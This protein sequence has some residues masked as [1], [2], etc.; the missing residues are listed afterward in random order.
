MVIG[1]G[2]QGAAGRDRRR[3]QPP[4]Q[5]AHPERELLGRERLGEVVVGAEREAADPV[6]LLPPRGQQD[7]ADVLGLVPLA[8]LGQHVVA[9]HAGQHEVEDHDVGP[10]LPRGLERVGPGIGGRDPEAALARW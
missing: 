7:D 5:A 9:R 1:P 4:E 3:G 8:Q 10:L 6:G 2:G